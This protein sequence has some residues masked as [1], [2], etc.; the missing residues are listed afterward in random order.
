MT[1]DILHLNQD[2]NLCIAL[3]DLPAGQRIRSGNETITLQQDIP[4]GHKIALHAIQRGNFIKKYGCP[5]G[6]AKNN[7]EPG[8][9]LHEH[10]IAM[11][12]ET[13]L[14]ADSTIQNAIWKQEP[15]YFSFEGFRRVDNKVGTRNYIGI[16]PTVSCA[17]S[18]GQFI[19]DHFTPEILKKYPNVDGVA[20][21]GHFSG[22]GIEPNK[23]SMKNLR[24]VITGYAQHPNFA[25]VLLIGLGCE[26]NQLDE[27]C[28]PA[29]INTNH[30][31]RAFSIQQMGGTQKS[32]EKGISE[33]Y[34][35]LDT[36]NHCCREKVSASNLV[37]GL[38]CGGSDAFSGIY[39]NPALGN[40]VDRLVM[41]GGTA[42]LSETTEIYGAEHL[43]LA[44]AKN[45]SVAEKLRRHITWWKNHAEIY[46]VTLNNNPTPGNKKGGLTNIIE[47]SLGAIT[48][49]GSTTLNQ[50]YEY[51]EPVSE[52]G[53]LFMDSPGYDPMSI[54]G[55]IASGANIICF[56]TGRGTVIGTK[57]SPCIKLASNSALYEHLSNDM[58][59]NCGDV[60]NERD[61]LNSAG[62]RIFRRIL[63]VASGARVK[64]EFF[65]FG[66]NEFI[67]W[68]PGIFT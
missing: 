63:E 54:T 14:N 2:D 3:M 27:L 43:L 64:S 23:I 4:A 49:A 48:K 30:N 7:I 8:E 38:E 37:L 25:A 5:I 16:I 1:N 18:V 56:T 59:I 61:G 29:L 22:C 17:A 12:T 62:E 66:Q 52:K 44:R 47:K 11:P 58:D 28:S 57:P 20:A 10:N 46:G 36:A 35:F 33:I 39:A 32:V 15:G 67:P 21:L 68:Q 13:L 6:I 42:I 41:S 53:L 40:A 51:A 24:R 60:A 19:A 50:V 34:R 26:K 55:M 31:I 65:P 45:R 9:H